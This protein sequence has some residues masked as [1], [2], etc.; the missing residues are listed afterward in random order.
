MTTA[1]PLVLRGRGDAVLRFTGEAVTLGRADGEYSI[2]LAAIEGV[3]AEGRSVGIELIALTD[4]EPVVYRVEDVS[5]AAATAFADA[6]ETALPDEVV[7]V[8]GSALVTHRPPVAPAPRDHREKL[9]AAGIAV[10]VLGLDVFLGVAGR[11]EYALT[12]WIAFAVTAIGGFLAGDM[13]RDLYRMWRLPRYGITVTA[14]SWHKAYG[15]WVY[16]YRD[17]TGVLH[18]Y[19]TRSVLSSKELSYDPRDPKAVTH[20]ED[21]PARCG[22][23]FLTL[24]GC[25]MAGGGLFGIGWLVLE[26]LKG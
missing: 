26:V 18:T 8:D 16:R 6:V 10:P 11:L 17:T 5:E 1:S 12:F 25:G 19:K 22:M 15:S 21:A 13:G 24:L 9:L 20:H 2:P 23:A 14:E 7:D 4:A 3:Y